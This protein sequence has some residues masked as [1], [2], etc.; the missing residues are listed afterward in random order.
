MS[1]VPN[2]V[3][4]DALPTA[5][6]EFEARLLKFAFSICRDQELAQDAVQDT[7]LRLA[8]EYH[9]LDPYELGRWLFTVCRNRCADLIRAGRRIVALNPATHAEAP[10]ERPGPDTA[11]EQHDETLLMLTAVDALP[12]AQREVVRLRYFGGLAYEEI[13]RATQ[14]TTGTVGWLLHE[15]LKSLR[16]KLRRNVPAN[17]SAV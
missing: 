10:D 4:P 16:H 12:D 6:H 7:F 5:L 13:A 15:A 8:K 9:R 17:P 1:S 11:A 3:S 14:Q 2:A